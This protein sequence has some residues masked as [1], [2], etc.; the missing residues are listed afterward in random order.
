MVNKI[1]ET[2]QRIIYVCKVAEF[3]AALDSAICLVG[4]DGWVRSRA[5]KKEKKSGITIVIKKKKKGRLLQLLLR[6]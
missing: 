6:R 3:L 1:M 4:N 2:K 5:K